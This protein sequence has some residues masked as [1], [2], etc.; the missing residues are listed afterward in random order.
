[1]RFDAVPGRE[2]RESSAGGGFVRR[3]SPMPISGGDKIVVQFGRDDVIRGHKSVY[4]A[5]LP[6]KL[7]AGSHDAKHSRCI[8]FRHFFN[9][10]RGST[11]FPGQGALSRR[12]PSLGHRYELDFHSF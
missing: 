1:M 9:E 12:F 10:W 7:T 11:R 2:L 3:I 5:M 6:L 4:S 8:T